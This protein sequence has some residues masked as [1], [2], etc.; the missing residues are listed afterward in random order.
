MKD[1]KFLI[2]LFL[3][4]TYCCT[5]NRGELIPTNNKGGY[6]IMQSENKKDTKAQ[7]VLIFGKV[8]DIQTK[9]PLSNT[10]VLIGC[11]KFE[12]TSNG[13]YLFKIKK[14]DIKLFIEVSSIGYKKI[15]TN[16][17]NFD[18]K[19]YFNINFFLSEDDKPL[20]DCN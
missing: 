11:L 10:Q 9:A 13:E 4:V 3:G 15:Q 1:S 16:F 19:N 2:L 20:I 18:S 6:K 17:L 12:T 7:E 14:S 8:V 5:S